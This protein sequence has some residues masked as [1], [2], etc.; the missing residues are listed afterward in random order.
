MES[1]VTRS[2]YVPYVRSHFVGKLR[3]IAKQF[4]RLGQFDSLSLVALLHS[5]GAGGTLM[6]TFFS[7][8]L[9]YLSA[10]LPSLTLTSPTTRRTTPSRWAIDVTNGPTAKS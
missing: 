8:V 7:K 3:V 1:D 6:Q 9:P 10:F 4:L 5:P 2:I